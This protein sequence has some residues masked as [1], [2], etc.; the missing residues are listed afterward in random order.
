[1]PDAA[2]LSTARGTLDERHLVGTNASDLITLASARAGTIGVTLRTGNTMMSIDPS[3]SRTHG[4][5]AAHLKLEKPRFLF[6]E[7]SGGTAVAPGGAAMALTGASTALA[8]S[9]T[10]NP[11]AGASTL[12]AGTSSAAASAALGDGG[13]GFH[14][15]GAPPVALFFLLRRR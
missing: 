10:D 12:V 6:L 4:G 13:G 11:A 3:K 15:S 5:N 9:S 8:G 1:M 2:T 7:G 14:L